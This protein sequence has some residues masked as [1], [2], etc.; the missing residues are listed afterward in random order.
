MENKEKLLV[1]NACA[2]K[3]SRTYRLARALM[4]R[5]PVPCEIDEVKLFE[6]EMPVLDEA[7][8]AARDMAL[9]TND[10]S[11]E[12]FGQAKKFAEA[13][14]II[15]AAPYWDLSF[16]A[17]LKQ[18]LEMICINGIT[19]RYTPEGMPV[20]MCKAKKLY[21]VTTAGGEIGD[22]NF[23]YDYVKNLATLLLGVERT[24]CIRAVGLDIYGVDTEAVLKNAVDNL[25]LVT[26]E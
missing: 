26:G 2:R 17:V 4:D 19:F 13:D 5:I 16:P 1:I 15:V 12:Y 21:Y 7:R 10:F 20:G 6:T 22:F 18:Y 24:Y 8:I 3:E 9:S 25:A 14:R 11:D 23:G